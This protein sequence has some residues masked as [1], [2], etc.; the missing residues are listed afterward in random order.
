[1]LSR[2]TGSGF[3]RRPAMFNLLDEFLS[4]GLATRRV[5]R[6]T[7]TGL[8]QVFDII[9]TLDEDNNSAVTHMMLPGITSEQVDVSVNS[10]SSMI[11]V[12]VTVDS[13]EPNEFTKQSYS[14]HMQKSFRMT[15]DYDV[16]Q[17]QVELINGVLTLTTPRVNKSPQSVKLP[18]HT[19]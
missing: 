16:E 4:P 10:S 13:E 6:Y 15:S 5:D 8:P 14:D 11:N 18:I 3:M 17:T 9:Q 2:R 19:K 1:M 12:V 7:Q